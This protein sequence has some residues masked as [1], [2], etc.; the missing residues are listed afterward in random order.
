MAALVV[1][2]RYMRWTVLQMLYN[3]FQSFPWN[4][5][6]IKVPND[7][8]PTALPIF[9]S[10][11]CSDCY[12]KVSLKLFHLSPSVVKLEGADSS[13]TRLEN[14]TALSTTEYSSLGSVAMTTVKD[15][16]AGMYVSRRWKESWVEERGE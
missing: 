13:L 15:P 16:N 12:L 7:T 10:F 9:Q 8:K 11:S 6:S 14:S 5:I 4:R 1:A 2:E 3:T